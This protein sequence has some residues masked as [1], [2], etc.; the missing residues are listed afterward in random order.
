MMF[1]VQN[2]QCLVFDIRILTCVF[3]ESLSMKIIKF[4][5]CD[6]ILEN[7]LNSHTRLIRFYWPS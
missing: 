6:W 4:Y 2:L 3:Y 5:I 7:R 1:K